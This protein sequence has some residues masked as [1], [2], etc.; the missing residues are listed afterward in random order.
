M[1]GQLA[2]G[3]E[4]AE[5]Q[6]YQM[7]GPTMAYQ[8]APIFMGFNHHAHNMI[9]PPPPLTQQPPPPQSP[10][11]QSPAL[12]MSL[13]MT[14]GN[15]SIGGYEDGEL[16]GMYSLPPA[17]HTQTHTP[18]DV[19]T[20]DP[21]L[22]LQSYG[23]LS[24]GE[25]DPS[26]HIDPH[27]LLSDG[28]ADEHVGGTLDAA[29]SHM[30]MMDSLF[31]KDGRL[32]IEGIA[33]SRV[34]D[35]IKSRDPKLMK[36][37]PFRALMLLLK[38]IKR[39]D[40]ESIQTIVK[41]TPF[42][43]VQELNS[44]SHEF[45]LATV[46]DAC[47]SI[48]IASDSGAARPNIIMSDN[49]HSHQ[50]QLSVAAMNGALT[51]AAAAVVSEQGSDSD[52]E[53]MD[54]HSSSSEHGEGLSHDVDVDVDMDTSSDV[55]YEQAVAAPATPAARN[56]LLMAA[57]HGY[58]PLHMRSR[59]STPQPMS[60]FSRSRAPSP[61]SAQPRALGIT[62]LIGR[63]SSSFDLVERSLSNIMDSPP[64]FNSRQ[65][66]PNSPLARYPPFE[67]TPPTVE[68]T[69]CNSQYGRL[70]VYVNLSDSDYDGDTDDAS[71]SMPTEDPELL[72]Q[73]K[74]RH[75]EARMLIS[76]CR[77][78]KREDA[79]HT[80]TLGSSTSIAR[81]NAGAT[82]AAAL[83]NTPTPEP[84]RDLSDEVLMKTKMNLKVQEEAIAQMKL[85]ISRRK[86]KMLLRKKLYE[87]M[88]AQRQNTQ[89]LERIVSAPNTPPLST[90]MAVDVGPLKPAGSDPVSLNSPSG[91]T[92]GALSILCSPSESRNFEA[93]KTA[94]VPGACGVSGSVPHTKDS[95]EAVRLPSELSAMGEDERELVNVFSTIS[96]LR[97]H[98]STLPEINF[99]ER[100]ICGLPKEMRDK[101]AS[102][103]VAIMKDAID[104][105]QAEL[106]CLSKDLSQMSIVDLDSLKMRAAK[107]T[108]RLTARQKQLCSQRELAQ[109]R[110]RE[111]QQSTRL[112]ELELG[113]LGFS[114]DANLSYRSML[115]S[116]PQP[117]KVAESVDVHSAAL[118]S[119]IAEILWRVNSIRDITGNEQ[120]TIIAA[121]ATEMMVAQRTLVQPAP[122]SI[123]PAPP[124]VRSTEVIL[125]N[126][127]PEPKKDAPPARTTAQVPG[128]D[129]VRAKLAAINKDREALIEKVAKLSKKRKLKPKRAK[130]ENMAQ[131]A[132]EG[133][134]P[135]KQR[136]SSVDTPVA[137]ATA[138]AATKP[139]APAAATTASINPAVPSD[140][141]GTTANIKW[142]SM[143]LKRAASKH[144]KVRKPIGDYAPSNTID[145]SIFQPII[146]VDGIGL[147]ATTGPVSRIILTTTIG[148]G[149]NLLSARTH[150]SP[151]PAA[152]SVCSSPRSTYLSYESPFGKSSVPST[153]TFDAS[154]FDASEFDASEFDTGTFSQDIESTPTSVDNDECSLKILKTITVAQIV[155]HFHT[156]LE[157]SQDVI[158][159]YYSDLRTALRT[160]PAE[161]DG[162]VSTFAVAKAFLPVLSKFGSIPKTN[163][164]LG[165]KNPLQIAIDLG[166]AHASDSGF[167]LFSKIQENKCIG[168]KQLADL[169]RTIEQ[170]AAFPPILNGDVARMSNPLD[171]T[172]HKAQA[173][174]KS[175]R[176]RRYYEALESD[177]DDGSAFEADSCDSDA[178][179]DADDNSKMDY[180]EDHDAAD[181]DDDN[182][183]ASATEVDPDALYLRA[184]RILWHGSPFGKLI[185]TQSR[186]LHFLHSR[187]NVRLGK[188]IRFLKQSLQLHPKSEKLWDLYLEL[189]MRQSVDTKEIVSAFSDAIKFH[190]Q[191]MIIW[192][193]YVHW[194]GWNF[195]HSTETLVDC[196]AWHNRLSV[197]SAAAIKCLAGKT[198]ALLEEQTSAFVVEMLSYFWECSWVLIE[199][200]SA[201]KVTDLPANAPT[202]VYLNRPRLVDHMYACLSS[203]SVQA[204]SDNITSL[205]TANSCIRKSEMVGDT[206][207]KPDAWILAKLLLPHHL[208]FIGHMFVFGF[209]RTNKIHRSVMA[210][211][212]A[213]MR[214]GCRY[215]TTYFISLDKLVTDAAKK[216]T[217]LPAYVMPI[218]H[219]LTISIG[220][221]LAMYDMTQDA[222]NPS[223]QALAR[224]RELCQ[225]SINA[226]KAQL[227]KHSM[228]P[229]ASS[230]RIITSRED[231]AGRIE[232]LLASA[233]PDMQALS[234]LPPMIAEQGDS[235]FILSAQLLLHIIES[236]SLVMAYQHAACFLRSNALFI[237][238][239]MFIDTSELQADLPVVESSYDNALFRQSLM[240]SRALYYRMVGY[241]SANPPKSMLALAS[242][243][244]GS[245]IEGANSTYAQVRETAGIW[246]NIALSELLLA[247]F[248]S[249][250]T[251]DWMTTDSSP[252]ES[253]E[254][255]LRCA[256]DHIS[257]GS[258]GS[259]AYIWTLLLQVIM[260]QRSLCLNDFTQ[261]HNDLV[262]TADIESLHLTPNCFAPM[263][264]VVRA[265]ISCNPLGATVDAIGNYISYVAR[266]DTELALR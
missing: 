199:R 195:Q 70:V 245:G 95:S 73:E 254:L 41:G 61:P 251:V 216:E 79:S 113:L 227:A 38:C 133:T 197:V 221:V 149:S 105:K 39:D 96:P 18:V 163:K 9:L 232:S 52:I 211:M 82:V 175:E 128:I 7:P 62:P 31:R 186:I 30:P 22:M 218:V 107:V 110:I 29:D 212:Q 219:Q 8:E 99:L 59:E 138:P 57:N 178:D 134:A 182:N 261:M 76:E 204:L 259:R 3:L 56:Q 157:A 123:S 94:E 239:D 235:K 159:Q 85:E 35:I 136:S 47:M 187:A 179:A 177:S 248:V 55:E 137:T 15:K 90:E 201:I 172:R 12:Q 236:K 150:S 60:L 196:F 233:A 165:N 122:P 145:S 87:S 92:D 32:D 33:R 148:D 97:L 243:L 176:V 86:T 155:N 71:D 198:T 158:R 5:A 109:A 240:D 170:C 106:N 205:R 242:K 209:I 265:I 258:T 24:D 119:D 77:R 184:L 140:I 111:L 208:L 153:P 244:L 214:A 51:T 26:L 116:A 174:G 263:N 246:I 98:A 250:E 100:S 66:T 74:A 231:V 63:M 152:L 23:P 171:T 44:L 121:A 120:A 202:M 257:P 64:V 80:P 135:K 89:P 13:Q 164:T 206:I 75:E 207:W 229:K 215:Q 83:V 58:E 88:S 220:H 129:E 4:Y 143:L 11:P 264:F 36:G 19:S 247:H 114:R 256:L 93:P 84:N 104:A 190:T 189:Y 43:V 126:K 224:S 65:P 49:A 103:L 160:V 127:A 139:A 169:Q 101:H 124:V 131:D 241:N 237:A 91:S 50:R 193:R 225:A 20:T 230:A 130:Q 42:A 167:I 141:A 192:R 25:L 223:A 166:Q 266:G 14:F 191:S 46:T 68:H 222:T 108:D 234:A 249:D 125:T 28:E 81:L 161:A 115:S 147:P 69:L 117:P 217:S 238:R 53:D 144:I 162:T 194:C 16:A 253:A 40:P 185:P 72:A 154:E 203:E 255:W 112:A 181:A 200:Q 151:A 102:S 27:M 146:V 173:K 168:I 48:L 37:A 45:G 188:A 226:T 54:M 213:A 183:A 180:S 21:H 17:P 262:G 34:A 260:A 156:Q 6:P 118:R 67:P 1:G 78:L 252:I 2:P 228:V 210:G 132:T 10:P 142:L